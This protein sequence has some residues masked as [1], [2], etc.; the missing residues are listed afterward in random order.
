MR[1][2]SFAG[3]K[4]PLREKTYIMGILNVTPDSFSD[5][6]KWFRP[7][8]AIRHAIEMEENGASI[9]DIGAFST[10]P[11]AE[12]ISPAEEWKRLSEVL[13]NVIKQVDVP[14]SVDT[15]VPDVAE[16]CL[17]AGAAIINDVSG[18]FNP[19]I[20]RLVKSFGAGWI[21]MH[22]GVSISRAES[23]V[24]YK[25]GILS[26]VQA[27]FDDITAR[28]AEFGIPTDKICLDPGF[29]FSKN[30]EQNTELLKKI[31]SLDTHSAA[32][33]CALSRKR[34]VGALADE[35]NAERRDEATLA[36]DIYAAIH[37]ADIV[38]V[39]NVEL[40]TKALRALDGIIR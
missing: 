17:D 3:G 27:F 1:Y 18:I 38:R 26:S 5:G 30:A 19:E 13:P 40:H 24:E 32:L 7:D 16:K 22:G 31:G 8:D 10:R 29:G 20:A 34:F 9:I 21:T 12:Y 15:F 25:D 11:N 39:H 4:L 33:L 2:F 23:E 6:N 14:V 35:P 36:C 37:G 28:S